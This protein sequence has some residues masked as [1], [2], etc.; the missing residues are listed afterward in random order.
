[1][2][3]IKNLTKKYRNITAVD[4]LSLEIKKGEKYCLLGANGAGKS[5]IFAIITGLIRN[6]KGEVY[7][8][9]ENAKKYSKIK[10]K[11]GVLI[12][13]S[14]VYPHKTIK[15]SMEFYCN[16]KGIDKKEINP[17]VKKIGL[18]T[19]INKKVGELSHGV[20][21]LVSIAQ[22]IMGNPE[23]VVL[24]EPTSGLDPKMIHNVR[25]LINSLK[26]TVLLST[27]IVETA[28]K[29]CTRVGILKEG[30]LVYQGEVGKKNL[31][32][33]YLKHVK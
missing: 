20:A 7:V 22:A 28:E 5:T 13:D 33:L 14:F 4:N 32:T 27:H 10:D 31:E 30:K 18:N 12:Q 26:M 21:K 16:L 19:E 17:I 8:L 11:V 29:T 15:E 6:Y 9:G 25:K 2:I 23:L 1:M 24:D 3:I